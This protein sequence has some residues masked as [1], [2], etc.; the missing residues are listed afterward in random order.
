MYNNFKLSKSPLLCQARSNKSV[1][2]NIFGSFGMS[3]DKAVTI[4][5]IMYVIV[6]HVMFINSERK[7]NVLLLDPTT[8]NKIALQKCLIIN[9]IVPCSIVLLGNTTKTIKFTFN[10]SVSFN[11]ITLKY[12]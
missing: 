3:L 2:S 11:N 6:S 1:I 8:T 4:I 7:T 12:N 10:F 5:L 9:L